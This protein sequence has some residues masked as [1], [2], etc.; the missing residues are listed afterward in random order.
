MEKR[1]LAIAAAAAL[2][3]VSAVP[4]LAQ[5][6]V[7]PEY[8]W[9]KGD[10]V[11][12]KMD[13]EKASKV[14]GAQQFEMTQSWSY[15]WRQ[16]VKD[17]APDGT[18]TIEAKFET[19]GIRMQI[20]AKKTDFTFDPANPDDAKRA[21]SP[22]A[23]PFVSLPGESITYKVSKKGKL[24]AI[25]GL[26]ELIQKISEKVKAAPQGAGYVALATGA[27]ADMQAAQME[28]VF[29]LLPE[30]PVKPG[31]LYKKAKVRVPDVALGPL[32]LESDYTLVGSEP[33]DGDDGFKFTYTTSKTVEVPAAGAAAPPPSP[34]GA[35][36]SDAKG[37]GEFY[38]SKSKGIVTKNSFQ[39]GTTV[40]T[41]LP[42]APNG[43]AGAAA[44]IVTQREDLKVVVQ[45]APPAAA[46]AA[47]AAAPAAPPAEGQPK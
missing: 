14:T 41:P 25:N 42:A 38:L 33:L 9:V 15:V 43:A 3:A 28:G 36:L 2:L 16:E 17:V 35:K 26:P 4:V 6:A 27:L 13:V 37:A 29:R 47:E 1:F 5:E 44:G 11:R 39:S 30:K 10:V 32:I 12:Y 8:K 19:A 23:I 7:A 24:L 22:L 45:V 46:P 31:T 18:G 21:S 34:S 40:E 20:P